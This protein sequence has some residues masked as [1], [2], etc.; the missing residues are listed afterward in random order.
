LKRNQRNL[1]LL[2]SDLRKAK[3]SLESETAS[4]EG[5]VPKRPD[6]T[7]A[8]AGVVSPRQKVRRPVDDVAPPPLPRPGTASGN[9]VLAS[10]SLSGLSLPEGVHSSLRPTTPNLLGRPLVTMADVEAAYEA[11]AVAQLRRT[12]M[13]NQSAAL[14]IPA[15]STTSAVSDSKPVGDN[16]AEESEVSEDGSDAGSVEADVLVVHHDD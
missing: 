10:A 12:A 13:A 6:G 1:H 15:A 8:V 5:P 7:K 3:R 16:E 2:K 11:I 9:R 14:Q 4:G